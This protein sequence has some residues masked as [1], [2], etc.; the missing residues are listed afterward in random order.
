MLTQNLNILSD[1]A[2]NIDLF[3]DVNI[4]AWIMTEIVLIVLNWGIRKISK[5]IKVADCYIS[6]YYLY[7]VKTESTDV[8]ARVMNVRVA[9][10]IVFIRL[11][12]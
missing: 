4:I 1:S 11:L 7:T 3:K 6:V 8:V 12:N 2:L 9:T 10:L 5:F